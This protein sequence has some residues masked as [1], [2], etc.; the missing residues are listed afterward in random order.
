MVGALLEGRLAAR[1]GMR[2]TL[3]IGLVLTGFGD[4]LIP[5][6]TGKN[7]MVVILLTIFVA[8]F[9]FGMGRTTFNIGQISLRQRV[10]PDHMQGRMNLSAISPMS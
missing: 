1:F 2:V 10:T 9:F 4:L 7:A 3:M 6:V 8:Q 5:M